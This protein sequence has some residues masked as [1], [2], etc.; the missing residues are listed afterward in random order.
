M[1]HTISYDLSCRLMLFAA[2]TIVFCIGVGGTCRGENPAPKSEY[3]AAEQQVAAEGLVERITGG[4]AHDFKI[5][6][7]PEHRDGKD[8]FAFYTAD[9]GRI[10]LEGNNGVS[11]ASALHTYLKQ[12]CG[13]HLSWCGSCTE[14]PAELPR[15]ALRVEKSSPYVYRYYLNYCTFNYSISWWDETR[16]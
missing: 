14:L 10:V 13:F 12:S 8:W 11:V 2:A 3:D 7:T 9:D 15:P 4:H 5:V 6:V 1:H 16:W